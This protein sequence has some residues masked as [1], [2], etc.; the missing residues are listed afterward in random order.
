V[1]A[2][3][4]SDGEAGSK[5]EGVILSVGKSSARST[6]IARSRCKTARILLLRK[7]TLAGFAK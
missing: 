5:P 2:G 6:A 7:L 1:I 3:H 4:A